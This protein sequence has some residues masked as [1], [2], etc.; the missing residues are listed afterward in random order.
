MVTYVKWQQP[1]MDG[2]KLIAIH[3]NRYWQTETGLKMDIGGFV[4]A[5]EYAS[6]Q[7]AMLIGKPA[8]AFFQAALHDMKLAPE[9]VAIIGDDIE[10][11]IGGGKKAG[12]SGILG[13][14][15]VLKIPLKFNNSA[16]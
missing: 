3:K 6:D 7:Q 11:D 15:A 12:I 8:T 1:L 14:V 5:L 4:T 10:S 2:A 13:A 16:T 9:Q